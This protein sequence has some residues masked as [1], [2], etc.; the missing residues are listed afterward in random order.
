MTAWAPGIAGT[1][2]FVVGIGDG[3]EA[4]LPGGVPDLQFDVLAVLGLHRF[5]PEVHA[6]GGHVV[7]GELVVRETQQQA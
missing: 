2:T 4:F 6:N 7:L 5:E 3:S 1:F